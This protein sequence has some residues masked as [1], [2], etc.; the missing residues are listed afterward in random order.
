L[1]DT[2]WRKNADSDIS[3]LRFFELAWLIFGLHLTLPL[4]VLFVEHG[5]VG[6]GGNCVSHLLYHNEVL[7]NSAAYSFLL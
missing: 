7:L 3:H 4:I 1:V 6:E 2:F 5:L